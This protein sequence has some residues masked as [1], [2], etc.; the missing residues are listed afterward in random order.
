MKKQ[1]ALTYFKETKHTFVYRTKKENS[2]VT[3]VYLVK[4]QMPADKPKKIS[5]TVEFE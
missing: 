3:S 5:I 4:T 2:L 1:I